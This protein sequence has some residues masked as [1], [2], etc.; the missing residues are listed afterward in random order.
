M[1]GPPSIVILATTSETFQS[2]GK[3]TWGGNMR[4]ESND[5][6]SGRWSFQSQSFPSEKK[7]PQKQT[8]SK[9]VHWEHW[10][11]RRASW[12]AAKRAESSEHTWIHYRSCFSLVRVKIELLSEVQAAGCTQ[13]QVFVKV[14]QK[15]SKAWGSFRFP[16]RGCESSLL[17]CSSRAQQLLLISQL[18]VQKRD[19]CTVKIWD[20]AIRAKL[21]L[22]QASRR[23]FIS[24]FPISIHLS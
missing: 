20:P 7:E 2:E 13:K 19:A 4:T 12:N 14:E 16:Q 3:N 8:V 23:L 21:G 6:S 17:W 10:V 11:R 1:S 15:G 22:L 24:N 18:A 5:Q 9:P